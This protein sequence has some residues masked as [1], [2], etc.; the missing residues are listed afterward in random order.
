[1][2]MMELE[3]TSEPLTTL[4]RK[5]A[6]TSMLSTFLSCYHVV[7]GAELSFGSLMSTVGRC[8]NYVSEREG[9]SHKSNFHTVP[10]RFVFPYLFADSMH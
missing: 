2:G 7:G 10:N 9:D 1:M 3:E 6:S 4:R 5:P 8:L